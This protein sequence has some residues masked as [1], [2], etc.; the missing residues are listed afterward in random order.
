MSHMSEERTLLTTFCVY[1]LGMIDAE[2]GIDHAWH[3]TQANDLE[4]A[5]VISPLCK[6]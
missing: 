4:V 6:P 1:H 5:A 2:K 3:A